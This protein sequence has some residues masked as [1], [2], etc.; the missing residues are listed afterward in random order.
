[1]S[2][3]APCA[4]LHDLF[5]SVH[6]VDHN[7]AREVCLSCPLIDACA[8][9]LDEVLLAARSGGGPEGTWAGQLVLDQ[10][11]GTV[12]H[13]AAITRTERLRAEEARYTD[14]SARQA[15]A[16]HSKGDRSEWAITGHRVYD[17]WRKQRQ[18][19]ERLDREAS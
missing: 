14:L 15:H 19:I 17:R 4:G 16:A 3:P 9:R 7:R 2:T 5:D 1:M 6:P 13:L 18:R 8:R 10:G 12:R 11:R